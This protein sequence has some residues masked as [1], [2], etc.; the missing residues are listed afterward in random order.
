METDLKCRTKVVNK[1]NASLMQGV[2]FKSFGARTKM[3]VY[4]L[5]KVNGR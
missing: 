5:R 2:C 1:T 4:Y 3:L